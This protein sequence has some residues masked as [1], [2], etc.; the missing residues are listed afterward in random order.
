MKKLMLLTLLI[1]ATSCSNPEDRATGDPDSTSFNQSGNEKNLNNSNDDPQGQAS[2]TMS[3]TSASPS[4]LK[5]N[6]NSSTEG[7]NRSYKA[8]GDSSNNKK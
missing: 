1:Y 3:D 6:A 2:A 8:G 4:N 7:T 5:Q